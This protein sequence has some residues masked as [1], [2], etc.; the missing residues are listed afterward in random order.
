MLLGVRSGEW[1]RT[2]RNSTWTRVGVLSRRKYANSGLNG[3]DRSSSAVACYSPARGRGARTLGVVAASQM[4]R[5][6]PASFA[7]R[8]CNE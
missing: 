1:V 7:L 5:L 2:T 8:S 4:R 3:Y 6:E